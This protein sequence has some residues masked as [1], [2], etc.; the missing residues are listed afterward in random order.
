MC[1]MLHYTTLLGIKNQIGDPMQLTTLARQSGF[2][3]S[4]S[5]LAHS[6]SLSGRPFLEILYHDT[7][8]V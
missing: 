3:S 4:P 7:V 6:V 1:F 8:T 5:F 2:E